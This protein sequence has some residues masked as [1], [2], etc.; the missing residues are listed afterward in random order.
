MYNIYCELFYYAA[1]YC[2]KAI[3]NSTRIHHGLSQYESW[4]SVHAVIQG[5]CS[6]LYEDWCT[7]CMP[8]LIIVHTHAELSSSWLVSDGVTALGRERPLEH[9]YQYPY[10]KQHAETP[11]STA[12]AKWLQQ[13]QNSWYRTAV[14]WVF[15][16]VF[17]G[18]QCLLCFEHVFAGY[19]HYQQGFVHD[20]AVWSTKPARSY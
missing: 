5:I 1:V 2:R 6:S 19:Q 15:L 8:E 16:M 17:A 7:E 18:D 11:S 20:H 14:N 4:S 3:L 13:C 10:Q 12:I 9:S